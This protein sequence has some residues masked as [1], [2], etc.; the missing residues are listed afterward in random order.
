MWRHV[1]TSAE[2]SER[3]YGEEEGC[4]RL[5]GE[6]QGKA[7]APSLFAQQSPVLLRAQK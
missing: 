7:D 3:T 6:I 1:K 4:P 5:G 2:V